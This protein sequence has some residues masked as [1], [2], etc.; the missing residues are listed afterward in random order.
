LKA[1]S[2]LVCGG[3]TS[4]DNQ[5]DKVILYYSRHENGQLSKPSFCEF[6]VRSLE[7]WSKMRTIR[8][9]SY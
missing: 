8:Q 3:L 4:L 6:Q 9:Q 2:I 1:I 7:I 5:R